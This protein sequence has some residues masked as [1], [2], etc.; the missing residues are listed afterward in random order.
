[1]I[2][3]R[4]V[5]STTANVR[6]GRPVQPA[7][8][9]PARP[10]VQPGAR[11]AAPKPYVAKDF[12]GWNLEQANS[13]RKQVQN[14][15]ARRQGRPDLEKWQNHLRDVDGFIGTLNN[16]TPPP[17]P[18]PEPTP[19]PTPEPAPAPVG[20][21]EQPAPD[22]DPLANYQSPMTQW[23]LKSLGEG[24]NTMRAYEPKFFEGSPMYQ[25]QRDQGM[26]ALNQQLAAQGLTG[27]GAAIE[28]GN[29]F[30]AR[31]VATEADK[32]RQYADAQA[33][34][35]Q[36]AQQFIA[37][38]DRIE[39]ENLRDQANRNKDRQIDVG[40]FDATRN[41]AF[42]DLQVGTVMQLLGLSNQNPMLNDIYRALG[43][44]QGL[45]K[46]I[47][48]KQANLTGNDFAR[49]SGGGGGGGPAPLPPAQGPNMGLALAQI[50]ANRNNAGGN[51]SVFNTILSGLGSLF[52]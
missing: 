40:Q 13:W 48:D 36:D 2:P 6:P 12:T 37:N 30:M 52:R 27:S 33:Q 47:I 35:V 41:D 29:D 31:L 3:R 45:F 49:V 15:V 5:A 28:G 19:T 10:G 25:F 4:G 7:A 1:M 16:P 32:Q 34:R 42:R 26:K 51:Q 24:M 17:T 43:D 9:P 23:L 46:S 39:R 38:Y 21:P 8:R 18:T 44:Q 14:E 20:P 22:A 50:M 11:P